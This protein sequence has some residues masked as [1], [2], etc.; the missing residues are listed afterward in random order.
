M[1]ALSIVPSSSTLCSYSWLNRERSVAS[2]TSKDSS[3]L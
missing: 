1:L 3:R 2:V